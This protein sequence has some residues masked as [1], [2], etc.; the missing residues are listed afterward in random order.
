[1]TT[2]E[3]V[4]IIAELLA[5]G[6]TSVEARVTRHGTLE[7]KVARQDAAPTRHRFETGRKAG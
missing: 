5:Q 4:E 3:V 2:S 1:M 7:I 6:A